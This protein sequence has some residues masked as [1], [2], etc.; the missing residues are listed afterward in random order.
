VAVGSTRVGM[1]P[2]SELIK[3]RAWQVSSEATAAAHSRYL[4]LQLGA[5]RAPS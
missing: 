3:L 4:R 2:A 5:D 1:L